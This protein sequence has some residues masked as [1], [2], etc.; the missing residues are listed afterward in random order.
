MQSFK[1]YVQ[2]AALANWYIQTPET[3]F[4]YSGFNPQFIEFFPSLY[5]EQDVTQR[6]LQNVYLRY[7]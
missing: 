4:F 6:V 1:S 2:K 7:P 5:K 3:C